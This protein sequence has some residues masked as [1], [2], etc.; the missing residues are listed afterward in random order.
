[1][2]TNNSGVPQTEA[3]TQCISLAEE[4]IGKGDVTQ[5]ACLELSALRQRVQ[6]L[7]GHF[8]ICEEPY[9]G[10]QRIGVH[11]CERCNKCVDAAAKRAQGALAAPGGPGE[12]AQ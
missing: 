7:Q 5:E 9:F 12:K 2:P 6:E 11:K 3:I 8:C 1:M 4:V 10:A